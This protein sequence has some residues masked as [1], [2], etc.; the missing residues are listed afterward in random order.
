MKLLTFFAIF[1]CL[2][3]PNTANAESPATEEA[4]KLYNQAVEYHNAGEFDKAIEF[5]TKTIERNPEHAD[6]YWNRAIIYGEQ[7]KYALAISD[8]RTVNRLAPEFASAYGQLGWYLI[9]QGNFDE[10]REPC[11]KAS[12]LE[13]ESFAW[14]V[15][16]GH[17][18]LLTGDAT[19]ARE[20]Y[21]Q[22]LALLESEEQLT[23]GPVA[24]F[25]LFIKNGWQVE[26]CNRELE[27]MKGAFEKA[28]HWKALNAKIVA[29]HEQGQ[30]KEATPIAEV[31]LGIAE[32]VF[33]QSHPNVATSLNNLAELYRTQGKYAEAEPLYKRALAIDEKAFGPNHPS[34][35][36]DLNNLAGL[37]YAQGQYAEAEPL[38]KRALAIDEKAFGSEHPS[39]ATSLNNLAGLYR[40]QGKYAEAEPLYK[41]ALEILEKAFGKDHPNV[42]KSLNN[43]GLLYSAQGQYA[44]AEPLYKRSL[45]IKEKAFGKDHPDVATSLNNLASLYSAQG[46]YAQAE[47]LYKRA[48]EIDENTYGP[49]H[50]NVATSLNNLAFLYSDQG[51][52]AEA[53]PLYK[54][55][56]EIKEKAFGKDHPDVALSLN[57]L[58]ALYYAK[59]QYAEAE[60]LYKRSLAIWE[61]AFGP[62]HPDVANS[63]H[64]LA[65]L[66]HG[67]GKYAEAEPLIDRAIRILDA[68]TGYPDVRVNAYALRAKLLKLKGDLG[69]ALNN[70]AEALDSIEEMRPQ[71]GGGEETR[72]GFFEK[73]AVGFDWMVDWQLEKGDIEK[74]IEYAERGRARVLLDQLAAGKIDIR[75]SIPPDIR[76]PLEKR[77]SD[78]KARL[79]EYQQRITLMRS[80]KDLS[81]EER[82]NQIAEL[83]K[84]LRVADEEYQQIYEEIKNASPLW[85]DMITSGGKPVDLRT[86]QRSLVPAQNLMLLYQIGTEASHL[87]IIPPWGKEPEVIPLQVPDKVAEKLGVSAGPLTSTVLQTLLTGQDAADTASR[88]LSYFSKSSRGLKFLESAD[89]YSK[90][91]AQLFALWQILVPE[92]QWSKIVKCD[93]VIII[94]DGALHLLPFEMLVVQMGSSDAPRYWLDEGP[95]VRYAPS[96]TTLYNIEKRPDERV[97]PLPNQPFVLSLSNPIYDATEVAQMLK[98][99]K[100]EGATVAVPG[101][102]LSDTLLASVTRD[103]FERAGGSLAKLPGTARETE[104][105]QSVF[106]ASTGSV[107]SLM[108]LAAN[109]P[110]LREGLPGKR[111]IHLATHGLVDQQRRSLFSALAV[112]PPL[113]QTTATE[114]DGFLQLYEIYQLKLPECEL[115]VLSACESNVGPNIEG[116]GVFALSRG[117]LA[118]GARRVIASQ[119]AVSDESTAELMGAFFRQ[120]AESERSGKQM[121]YARALRD[122]KKSVRSKTRWSSPFYWAPFI[123]T[124][125]R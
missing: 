13:P 64:N 61:K 25:E 75:Q 34:V 100:V 9:L 32:E 7:K 98:G 104:V 77:E 1:C 17:T 86:I 90:A 42:A 43:L 8:L 33:G 10:A 63:L 29:L 67:Q 116:E 14:T 92:G 21:R 95:V 66:Y 12:A 119:W 27:W 18:Y 87:F 82:L 60:P 96:A 107:L 112:T 6:A 57:N 53:E 97:T 20:Y 28:Q 58:A 51:R 4:E 88:L 99:Q 103:S 52:Y 40:T 84:E 56:L 109:E 74:A 123:L 48:L 2:L 113:A 26:A 121:D 71:I 81:D 5:Y 39:V 59:G 83:E 76:V 91:T 105:I 115:T 72:A 49:S 108:E 46:Q 125:K 47:P 50:P 120:I 31:A 15:N 110:K 55:S 24:D 22:T 102:L 85:R 117:F 94:P 65:A 106:K 62:D 19:T 93:E 41:R 80:R 37:Y 122:A 79:A 44:Q 38:Y 118:T 89:S 54:R 16:L 111:Y 36:T 11:Q 45:E 114:D 101:A 68:T 78:A 3:L 73:Y 70:L 30:Y 69:G 35:A 23:T 124:G